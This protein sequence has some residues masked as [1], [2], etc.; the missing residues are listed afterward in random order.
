MS[1]V[2]YFLV[3]TFR[4]SNRDIKRINSVNEGRL[5]SLAS[6]T[7]YGVITIR[8]F[9]KQL[10]FLRDYTSKASD[11]I[12]STYASNS[13]FY[14]IGMRL[15]MLANSLLLAILLTIM[16]VVIFDWKISYV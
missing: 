12:S 4:K 9:G 8:A 10:M 15:R 5:L 13:C 2:S 7:A 11:A 3:G 16:F 1:I 6:E 14:W